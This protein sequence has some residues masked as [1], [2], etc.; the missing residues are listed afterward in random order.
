MSFK[1]GDD[2]ETLDD[3]FFKMATERAL[4]QSS[5]SIRKILIIGLKWSPSRSTWCRCHWTSIF[6]NWITMLK[7][8]DPKIVITDEHLADGSILATYDSGRLMN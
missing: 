5:Q 3:G 6:K 2:S 7:R 4:L 8:A 1:M